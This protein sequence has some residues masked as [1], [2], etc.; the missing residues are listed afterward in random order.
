MRLLFLA[1]SLLIQFLLFYLEGC[2]RSILLFPLLSLQGF[3]VLDFERALEA[4]FL[5]NAAL[6][7]NRLEARTVNRNGDLQVAGAFQIF[8]LLFFKV[9]QL[10]RLILRLNL[11]F[12]QSRRRANPWLQISVELLDPA[13][14]FP[15]GCEYEV[16][17]LL[18]LLADFERFGASS[19]DLLFGRLDFLYCAEFT[20]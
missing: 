2:L 6:V 3:I 12:I 20:D 19:L 5:V 15:I 8:G 9:A 13:A 17:V 4:G 1:R 18:Y 11:N 16:L 10:R 7:L 14:Q